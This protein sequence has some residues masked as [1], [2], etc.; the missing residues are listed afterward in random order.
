ME[1]QIILCFLLSTLFFIGSHSA[2]FTITNN[3]PYVIWPALLTS[4]G[5]I[6]S[7]TGFELPSQSTSTIVAPAPW[8]GRMWARSY[9]S[10]GNDSFNCQTGNC[11]SKQIPCNGL[12]GEPPASLIEFTLAGGG[13]LDF[14]D[15]SL[16]DGFNLPVTVTARDGCPST[17]CPVDLNASCPDELALKDPSGGKVGC[18]SACMVYGTPEY[19]CNGDHATPSTCGPSKYSEFF[20]SKCPQAYSYAYDD[21]T[22]T[23]TCPTG[24]D[25]RITFCP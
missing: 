11:G 4:S 14:Y 1:I 16:V 23:F 22:S 18:K 9:C 21:K 6:A 24:G 7:T 19:C 17:S 2:T 5:P 3:C 13:N 8:S 25:Y 20:K 15:V 12:G 10:G